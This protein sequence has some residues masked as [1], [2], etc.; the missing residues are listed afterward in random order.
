MARARDYKAEYAVRKARLAA[1]GIK[2][3][4]KKEY[5]QAIQRAIKRGFGSV[6]EQ[7][8]VSRAI[9]TGTPQG[10]S[11]RKQ[12][13]EWSDR[14]AGRKGPGKE[15]AVYRPY[16][17]GQ[18]GLTPAEYTDAYIDAWLN[19]DKSHSPGLKRWLVDITHYW[20]EEQY[21]NPYGV[22]R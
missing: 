3:D 2:R 13:Q 15:P 6:R 21:D 1:R 9:R 4:Y 16:E 8:R 5:D 22:H 18:Y 17:A 12:A 7:K 10:A 11:K 20:T 19:Y 14:Y